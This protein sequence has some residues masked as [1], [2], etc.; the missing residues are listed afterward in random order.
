MRWF[1]ARVVG[2]WFALIIITSAA[3]LVVRADPESPSL[4]AIGLSR[5]EGALCFRGLKIG[6]GWDEVQSRYPNG[7]SHDGYV[8]FVMI[9]TG[10]GKRVWYIALMPDMDAMPALRMKVTAGEIVAHFGTPCLL[11]L[12]QVG[13][14]TYSMILIYRELQVY[15]DVMIGNPYSGPVRR[16]LNPTSPV[17]KLWM[18]STSTTD[19][20]CDSPLNEVTGRWHG[21]LSADLYLARFRAD[22]AASR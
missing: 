1:V 22:R 4:K 12:R 8:A 10:D 6:S 17:T 15:A 20:T 18:I 14:E 2:L 3:V 9:P 7:A 13:S 5:C 16:Q 11:F 21:F 19:L